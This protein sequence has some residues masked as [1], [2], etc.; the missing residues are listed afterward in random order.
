MVSFSCEATKLAEHTCR[1]V[2]QTCPFVFRIMWV[3]ENIQHC[4]KRLNLWTIQEKLMSYPQEILHSMVTSP[5]S[6]PHLT[7][8]HA[9]THEPWHT[10]VKD[11]MCIQVSGCAVAP[12]RCHNE[13]NQCLDHKVC[14]QHAHASVPRLCTQV[15]VSVSVHV[16]ACLCFCVSLRLPIPRGWGWEIQVRKQQNKLRYNEGSNTGTCFPWCGGKQSISETALTDP[17]MNLKHW[18]F[19]SLYF[20]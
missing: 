12:F 13:R 2:E 8:A 6:N 14:R 15:C 7:W 4:H 20:H 1:Y 3:N 5:T 16:F 19:I 17:L 9:H 10:V 11:A 18:Y